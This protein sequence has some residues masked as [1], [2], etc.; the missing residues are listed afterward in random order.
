MA[1]TTVLSGGEITGLPGCVLGEIL[2]LPYPLL[3]PHTFS[4]LLP[5]LVRH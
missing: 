5:M 1:A 4:T 2:E 3:I